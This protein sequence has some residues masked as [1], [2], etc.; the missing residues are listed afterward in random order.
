MIELR[1]PDMS[2]GHCVQVVT[3]TVQ[4]IDALAKVDV[5]LEQ[6]RVRIESSREPREFEA[7]LAEAGYPAAH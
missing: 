5:E 4:R 2:C 3:K 7:A 6:R 1:L